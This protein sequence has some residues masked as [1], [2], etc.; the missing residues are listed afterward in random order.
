MKTLPQNS[1]RF[2]ALCLICAILWPGM[3]VA[4][5]SEQAFVLLLPTRHY[6]IGGCLSVAASILLVSFLPKRVVEQAFMPIMFR[7]PAFPGGVRHAV[8]L[9]SFLLVVA[10]VTLGIIGPRD[11]LGNL[12]PL[13]IWTGWWVVI[14][15]LTGLIGNLWL[16]INPWTGPYRLIF[17]RVPAAPVL[18]LPDICGVWPA[19]ALFVLFFSFF[20]ADPAPND[21]DRLAVIVA[22]YWLF[23]FAGM[24]LFGGQT[25]LTRVEAFTVAFTL[26][27]RVSPFGDWSRPAIGLPGWALNVPRR[28]AAGL[29]VFALALLA[30]GSFDGLKETFWWMGLIRV[31][32]LEFPGRSA[33]VQSSV[34]GLLLAVAALV[35]AFAL[36]VW[37]CRA[38]AAAGHH[39]EATPTYVTVFATLAPAILPIAMGY[40]ISHFL[41]SFLIEGQYLLAAIGDPFANGSN[42]LGLGDV[43]VT[44]GFLNSLDSVNRIWLTQAGVVVLGHILSVLVAHHAALGLFGD[45]RRA[46]L[47][48][49]PLGLFMILYTLFGLWLLATPRGV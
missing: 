33:V 19:I 22:S 20:I 11:P 14:V 15:S 10:L 4:H 12:L 42:Y 24:A 3:A 9:L 39:A 38:I 37:A 2:A 32:P 43:R 31:N 25:W 29:G 30:A 6:I 48:Q 17:G 18:R 13:M 1:A 27:S 5:V 44:T 21:P 16:W 23:T 47:S 8:S 26:L 40:H 41:V 36:V 28:Y 49:I 35:V 34:I 46:A 7:W 45:A